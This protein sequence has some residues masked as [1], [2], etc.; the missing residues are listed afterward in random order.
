MGWKENKL[1]L[2]IIV[3]FFVVVVLPIIALVGVALLGFFP[4][5]ASDARITQSNA[6]WGNEARPFQ[7]TAHSQS[8]TIL[9]LT[10]LNSE[11]SDLTVTNISI[12]GNAMNEPSVF[13][14]G[15]KKDIIVTG[16]PSCQPGSMYDFP[17]EIRYTRLSSSNPI[18]TQ[19]GTKTIV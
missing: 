12:G 8:G 19:H 16:M 6:Y 13:S 15:Q 1:L 10:L 11:A 4:G 3:I 18:F 9:T 2:A 7:I 14:A 5:A 17:V